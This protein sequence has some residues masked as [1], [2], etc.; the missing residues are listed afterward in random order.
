MKQTLLSLAILFS[1]AILSSCNSEDYF[2]NVTINGGPNGVADL[3]SELLESTTTAYTDEQIDILIAEYF[4]GK[5]RN[6]MA[7]ANLSSIFRAQFPNARDVEWEV[8]NDKYCVEFEIGDVDYKI[9]YDAE[10]NALLYVYDIRTSTLPKAVSDAALQKYPAYR[11]DDAERVLK[12]SVKAYLLELEK[13][14][15]KDV[16]VV[17]SETG[18]FLYEQSYTFIPPATGGN[19]GSDNTSNSDNNNNIDDGNTGNSDSNGTQLSG[20]SYTSEQIINLVIAF[21]K[22]KTRRATPPAAVLA[23]F[24]SQ[25]SNARDIEWE[26]DNVI[27]NVEFEIGNVDYEAWYDAN[28]VR[29]MHME[30]IRTNALPQ[31]VSSAITRD[32]PGFRI[33]DEPNKIFIN[34][35]IIYEISIEKG[36][37]ELGVYYLPD[38]TFLKEIIDY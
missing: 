7:P 37:T 14:G 31:T 6:T 34:S 19:S 1:A 35:E 22:T 28:G 36:K 30:E 5:S 15:V 32:Y 8:S 13:S 33:D 16:N 38:G 27:Y 9:L 12:G 23:T 2:N 26:T 17:F 4:S 11:I 21:E 25:Y 24:R 20:D 3:K 10:G 18:T 29:L